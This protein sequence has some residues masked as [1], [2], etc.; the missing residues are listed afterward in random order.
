MDTFEGAESQLL[1]CRSAADAKPSKYG[2]FLITLLILEIPKNLNRLSC[3]FMEHLVGIIAKS[4]PSDF[5]KLC[6]QGAP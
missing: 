6:L 2:F 4:H 3:N 1:G 5:L